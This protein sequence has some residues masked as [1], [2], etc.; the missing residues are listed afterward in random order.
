MSPN[1]QD[2]EPC[3]FKL[4]LSVKE[5]RKI[6]T[7]RGRMPEM[8]IVMQL[9]SPPLISYRTSQGDGVYCTTP[10][11]LPDDEDPWIRTVDFS[12]HRSIGRCLTYII[13]VRPTEYTP[14]RRMMDFFMEQR[15]CGSVL[16]NL[17][18]LYEEIDCKKGQNYFFVHHQKGVPFELMF[19]VNALVHRG[20]INMTS[21]TQEFYET[22]MSDRAVSL[23][24]LQHML[25]YTHPV[26]NAV[27]RVQQVQEWTRKN[28]KFRQGEKALAFGSI[29]MYRVL[30]TPTRGICTL[31]V[32]SRSN[33]VLRHYHTLSDRFLRVSFVDEDLHQISPGSLTVPVSRSVRCLSST[34][35]YNRTEIHRRILDIVENGFKLCG[36]QYSFLAFSSSQMRGGSAWFFASTGNVNTHL[37]RQ[38][39]GK[40]PSQNVA[41]YAAR[42]GQCFSCSFPTLPV[43][44]AMVRKLPDVVRNGYIFSDGCGMIAPDFALRVS[45]SLKLD[46]TPSVYQIR[47]AGYKGVVSTWPI[48]GRHSHLGLR[49]SMKKFESGHTELEVVNWS[50]YLP[51]YLNRQIICLLSTLKVENAVFKSLQ[52]AQVARLKAMLGDPNQAYEIVTTSCSDSHSTAATML[53]GGFLPLKEP[54]LYELL[55]SIKFSLLED[56]VSK[57]RIF[58]PNGRWVIGCMDETGLLNYGQCFIHVSGPVSKACLGGDGN[59]LGHSGLLQVITGKVIMVKN[60][61]LHPG[62][63][64]ILEAVDLPELHSMVDCLVLPQNGPRPHPNEVSGS[65]LDG[66]VYFTCWDPNLIPPSGESWEPMEYAAHDSKILYRPANIKDVK[67]FF[68]NSMM[69]DK[70]GFISNAH[71]ARADKSPEGALDSDC[72]RLAHLAS[73][74]VDFPKT[75]KNATMPHDLRVNEWP[76]FMEK[77]GAVTYQ[78]NKVIGELYRSVTK[79][80]KAEVEQHQHADNAVDLDSIYDYDLQVPG[81]EV[82]L[83]DAW[84]KK[85]SYDRQLRCMMTHFN[86]QREAALIASWLKRGSPGLRSVNRNR[87]DAFAQSY[88]VLYEEFRAQ[89]EGL[90]KGLDP[91]GYSEDMVESSSSEIKGPTDFAAKASAWYHVTYHPEWKQKALEIFE[92]SGESSPRPLLSFP[93][94]TASVL[95]NIKLMKLLK[96]KEKE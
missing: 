76:D 47:Y 17:N 95:S 54:H 72:L 91:D 61:C 32:V 34:Y 59:N 46:Y 45:L 42:M 11:P 2:T 13:S 62:D 35:E 96:V 74:A 31:P 82:Y 60:P 81:Y 67:N 58:V 55:V 41:K 39:M 16:Q 77:E 19:L 25:T 89:F 80:L 49:D 83:D 3:E 20:I 36:R 22:V 88:G 15:L 43:L 53:R 69:N 38:W 92:N 27:L 84:T 93:W 10:V 87:G 52:D 21:L 4:E 64:R 94:I 12:P 71:V 14:F 78:S 56:L 48:P 28:D 18:F 26:F 5:V 50:K 23:F 6:Q 63:I 68:V 1:L 37:I 86:V 90:K 29:L 73:I 51:C 70:L 79:F 75:G 66:D 30:F 40:F 9:F 33:R 7:Q 85:I 24:A 65:D 8:M 44:K 57:A